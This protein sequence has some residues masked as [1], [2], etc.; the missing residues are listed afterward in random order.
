MKKALL[1]SVLV[2]PLLTGCGLF[3]KKPEQNVVIPTR[4]I[5]V[6]PKLLEPCPPLAT[7]VVPQGTS[8][9][10]LLVLDNVAANSAIY[11]KCRDDKDALVKIIKDISNKETK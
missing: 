2:L 1:I 5:N 8:D 3:F 10:Y 11:A 6:E 7:L 4:T 9:P